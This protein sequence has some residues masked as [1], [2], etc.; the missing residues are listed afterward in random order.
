MNG[1]TESNCVGAPWVFTIEPE[2]GMNIWECI[3]IV[4]EE[5]NM[6]HFAG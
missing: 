1:E 5:K 2:K 3:V 4:Y 6:F